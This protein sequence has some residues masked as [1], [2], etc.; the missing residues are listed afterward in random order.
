M[1][2]TTKGGM[3]QCA[4]AEQHLDGVHLMDA[5]RRIIVIIAD[6][7]AVLTVEGGDIVMGSDIAPSPMDRIE[8]QVAYTAMMTGTLLEV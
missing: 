8:A 5:D 6:P 4:F 2:I 1:I 7:A 3:H